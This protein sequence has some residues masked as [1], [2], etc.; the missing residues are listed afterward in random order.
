VTFDDFNKCMLALVAW[1]EERSNG[2]NG[3][4]GVMFVIRNRVKKGWFGGDY[5]SNIAGHNQFSS[6]SVSGDSQTVHYPVIHDPTFTQ[7]LQLTD[8]VYDDT[9]T[10]TI[11]NGA[12]Y[13]ADMA[14]TGYNHGGWFDRNIAQN[15]I[16]HPRVAVIG[17]TTY[18]G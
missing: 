10:D 7:L 18:F 4:L 16:D 9:R 6:M 14:S 12:L 17:T 5:L 1:R 8:E 13:Y 3:M 15:A 11:T 2:I